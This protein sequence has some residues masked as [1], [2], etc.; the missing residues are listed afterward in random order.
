MNSEE[1][2]L[3]RVPFGIHNCL[4]SLR[5]ARGLSQGALGDGL[6]V[7]RQTI[8]SIETGKQLPSLGFA[9]RIARFFELEIEDIFS[10]SGR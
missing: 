2:A 4:K 10:P 1:L 7:S 3:S 8:C 6:G 9:F 5:E